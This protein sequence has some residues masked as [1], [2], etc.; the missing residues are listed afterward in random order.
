[1]R[2]RALLVFCYLALA[3][4]LA[5]GFG[6]VVS[7][8]AQ[9]IR[10]CAASVITTGGTAITAIN[11]PVRGG[12][13]YNP[14]STAGQGGGLESLIVNPAGTA[15]LVGSGLNTEIT[16]GQTYSLPGQLPAGSSISVNAATSG[17]TFTCVVW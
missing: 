6:L 16:P 11:G 10:A 2:Q 4:L 14:P 3:A 8:H 9:S 5:W 15:G 12:Y 7:S 1:M 13:I 17:H